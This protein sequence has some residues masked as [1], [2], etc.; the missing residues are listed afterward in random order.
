MFHESSSTINSKYKGSLPG[1]KPRCRGG[2]LGRPDVWNL[3]RKVCSA[4]E[5]PSSELS[6]DPDDCGLTG[7]AILPHPLAVGRNG[8]GGDIIFLVD[9]LC[10]EAHTIVTHAPGIFSR[11]RLLSAE[12]T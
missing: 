1:V 10:L 7:R 3:P 12:Q 9:T 4:V 8:Q 2:L 5:F 6:L 11:S